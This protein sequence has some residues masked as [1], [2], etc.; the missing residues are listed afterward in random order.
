MT[1]SFEKNIALAYARL[2]LQNAENR[3]RTAR[4]Q[5]DVAEE[6]LRVMRK[7]F[8]RVQVQLE[9]SRMMPTPT[10]DVE[11]ITFEI[12]LKSGLT[13]RATFVR[14]EKTLELIRDGGTLGDFLRDLAMQG[15]D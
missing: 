13:H 6:H 14:P 10:H 2:D 11:S 15:T 3:V 1:V 4:E 12:V 9:G 5:C 8:D 7:H